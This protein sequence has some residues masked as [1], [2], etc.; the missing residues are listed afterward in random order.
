MTPR[1]ILM[2]LPES[3]NPEAVPGAETV[4][5]FVIKNSAGVEEKYTAEIKD[6]KCTVEEGLNGESK[7]TVTTTEETFV[8]V[9]N[10]SVNP[11]MAVFMGKLKISNLGEMMKY[12]KTFGLM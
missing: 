7:C 2:K 11:Q 3:F 1:D 6:N 10:K 12:A 9:I 4:F 5:H 8:G